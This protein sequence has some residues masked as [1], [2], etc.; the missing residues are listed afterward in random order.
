MPRRLGGILAVALITAASACHRAVH[1]ASP[2]L[3]PD[4]LSGI[5]S[6]TGTSFEQHLVLRSN[7]NATALSASTADSAALS[8]MG[9]IEVMVVG[10][11]GK[12]FRVDH[13]TAVSVAGARVVDGVLRD[14]G[15]R[16]VIETTS[17]RIPLGNPP[18]ALRGLIAGRVWIGG[19]LDT[20]PNT[21]G[22]IVPPTR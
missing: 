17:G 20:G 6:V 14:E 1:T 4:T 10:R 21:F 7:G 11:S 22:V 8:R 15:G 12:P 16:L 9:G 5:V 18:A 13:F 19:P 2:A 3:V